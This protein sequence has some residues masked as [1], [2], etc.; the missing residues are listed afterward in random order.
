M[1][2]LNLSKPGASNIQDDWVII[3]IRTSQEFSREHIPGSINLPLDQLSQ[4]ELSQF[5][6]K[7]L[8]FHC[9]AGYRTQQAQKILE[10]FDCRDSFCLV[11]GIGA[12]KAAGKPVVKNTKM[13][14]ELMRQVQIVA[15]SLILISF[16]LAYFFSTVF[17]V[18]SVFVGFGLLFAGI[19]GF[20]GMA[21]L[22]MLL[23]YNKPHRQ[24]E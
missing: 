7:T 6:N 24:G 14:L 17:L 10:K 5:K 20:C 12:W 19:T 3:D 11:G 18:I 16:A 13:P 1:K 21:R 4:V 9:Q 2:M 15:G 23:P 22:L 8:L